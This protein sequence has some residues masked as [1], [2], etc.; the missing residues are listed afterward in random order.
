[1]HEAKHRRQDQSGAFLQLAAESQPCADA[2]GQGDE[3]LDPRAGLTEPAHG[4]GGQGRAMSEREDER[5]AERLPEGGRPEEHRQHEQAMVPAVGEDMREP[6]DEQRPGRLGGR[7]L[8]LFAQEEFGGE[9]RGRG[10][11]DLILH[12]F[13]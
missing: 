5:A 13:A 10:H 1:M 12:A 4:H 2:D 3:G 11:D 8:R 7:G 6:I 9:V